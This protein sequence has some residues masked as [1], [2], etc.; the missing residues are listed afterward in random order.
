MSI[1]TPK[2]LGWGKQKGA[3]HGYP[4]FLKQSKTPSGV[5][6]SIESTGTI[7]HKY[8]KRDDEIKKNYP[9]QD[10]AQML[11]DWWS[12]ISTIYP[13]SS[14]INEETRNAFNKAEE[15]RIELHRKVFG[16]DSP[17]SA[18][19]KHLRSGNK[20]EIYW[21]DNKARSLGLEN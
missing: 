18:R 6:G 19:I 15:I 1:L 2:L 3:K 10:E 12:A 14:D 11:A 8:L 16:S 20:M 7:Q 4:K 13:S 17:W 5:H 9:R 21:D